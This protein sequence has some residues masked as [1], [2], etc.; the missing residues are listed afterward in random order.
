M[1]IRQIKPAWWLD[2]ALQT[3]LTADA[4]EFYIGLWMLADDAGWLKW[5]V[6]RVA[7]ELYPYRSSHSRESRVQRWAIQLT[8]LDPDAPHLV[9]EDC[10]HAHIPK[11]TEHQRLGGRPVETVRDAHARVCARSIAF[12]RA[13]RVG[14]GKVGNGSRA[15][16][17]DPQGVGPGEFADKLVA[18]GFDPKRLDRP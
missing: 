9:I 8:S 18:Y 3:R 10:G 11:L 5:D 15:D 13:G 1:R 7:A 12:A 4:R 2:K 6:S 17:T 14:K 16:P